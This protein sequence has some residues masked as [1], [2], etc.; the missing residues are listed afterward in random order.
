MIH[1]PVVPYTGRCWHLFNRANQREPR[2]KLLALLADPNAIVLNGHLHRYGLMT[3][4]VAPRSV[5]QFSV[6]S[7]VPDL[8]PRVRDELVGREAY[9]ASIT[10]LEPKFS[11]QTL[12]DRRK[13]LETEKEFVTRYEHA[14]T[15]GYAVIHVAGQTVT[16]DYYRGV[17][18]EVW[19]SVTIS[20]PRVGA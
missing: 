18:K 8:D 1:P 4:T 17:G 15:P 16:A 12:E 13:L 11:L 5:N 7:V 6:V 9:G 19:R 14:N 20:H 3:R 2:E 10:D